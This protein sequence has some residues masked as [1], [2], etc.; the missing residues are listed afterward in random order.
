VAYGGRYE[1]DR[2]KYRVGGGVSEAEVGGSG[3]VSRRNPA[4]PRECGRGVWRVLL[5]DVEGEG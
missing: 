3:N 2:Q 1:R 5:L 4:Y